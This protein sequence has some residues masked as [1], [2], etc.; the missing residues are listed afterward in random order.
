MLLLPGRHICILGDMLELGEN[1]EKLHYETGRYAAEKGIEMMFT[2]GPL[3]SGITDGFGGGKHFEDIERLIG[4]IKDLLSKD[5]IVLIKASRGM[6]FER[7][8]EA[9]KNM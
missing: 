7:I 2:C 3:A 6:R 5:D 4:E 1:E 9:I 8:T